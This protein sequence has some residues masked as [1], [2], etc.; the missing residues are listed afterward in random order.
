MTARWRILVGVVTGALFLVA[1]LAMAGAPDKV[2]FTKYKDKK[3]AVSFD[4]KAHVG[5]NIQCATCHHKAKDGKKEVSCGSCHQKEAAGTTP[6]F[7]DA[8]HKQCKDC[9]KKEG[10]GP[11][12]CAECHK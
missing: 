11:T 6:S 10:K 9:H 12:K 1:S 7:Q 2:D 5:R 3:S 4:H 8:F